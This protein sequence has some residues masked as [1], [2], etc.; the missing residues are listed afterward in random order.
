VLAGEHKLA[1]LVVD[2]GCHDHDAGRALGLERRDA[3]LGIERVADVDGFEESAGNLGECDQAIAG[4]VREAA[5]AGCRERQHLKTVGQ[6]VPMT[7]PPAI[8]QVVMD[9]MVVAR[10]AAGMPKNAPP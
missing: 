7:V 8:F 1:A 9:R 2:R 3:K 4:R 6:H 5:G 10:R